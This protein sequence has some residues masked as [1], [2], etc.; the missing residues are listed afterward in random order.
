MRYLIQKQ[1]QQIDDDLLSGADYTILIQNLPN[2]LDSPYS[3][4]REIE[5]FIHEILFRQL[6]EQEQEK[7]KDTKLV[8]N[9]Y[10]LHNIK[11]NIELKE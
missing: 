3:I 2:Q 5:A 7:Y 6:T 4:K 1:D 11:R 10:H 8:V 9:T